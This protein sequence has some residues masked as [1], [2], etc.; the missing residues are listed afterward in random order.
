MRYSRGNLTLGN[1]GDRR[2]RSCCAYLIGET[3]EVL[4]QAPDAFE[5]LHVHQRSDWLAIL[6]DQDTVAA[7]LDLVQEMAEI[8]TGGDCRGFGS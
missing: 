5:R 6:G 2:Q 1:G 8:L 3:K 4:A 7:V